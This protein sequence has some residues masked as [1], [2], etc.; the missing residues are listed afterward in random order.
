MNRMLPRLIFAYVCA[1]FAALL[2]PI[3]ALAS[4][5]NC[6]VEHPCIVKAVSANVRYYSQALDEI[7]S[8]KKKAFNK[9]LPVGGLVTEGRKLVDGLSMLKIIPPNGGNAVLVEET[10]FELTPA[11]KIDCSGIANA[12]L[13]KADNPT[14]G[15]SAGVSVGLGN[16]CLGK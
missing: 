13:G 1:C 15:T 11:K 12:I 14:S 3:P 16:P 8:I 5:I 7:S 2:A 4:D 9:L 6:S 10:D